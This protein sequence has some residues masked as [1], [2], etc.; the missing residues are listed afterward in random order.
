MS[1]SP[2][3]D[4]EPVKAFESKS[5]QNS[6]EQEIDMLMSDLLYLDLENRDAKR[7]CSQAFRELEI[8]YRGE[9]QVTCELYFMLHK[10]FREIDSNVVGGE[11]LK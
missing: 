8:E 2:T 1:K 7:V 5:Y 6:L 4:T 10:L 11:A 9:C 3:R